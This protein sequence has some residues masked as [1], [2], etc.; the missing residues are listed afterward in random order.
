M[1]SYMQRSRASHGQNAANPAQESADPSEGEGKAQHGPALTPSK[2]SPAQENADLSDSQGKALH[3][4][5][6]AP[7]KT[8][9]DARVPIRVVAEAAVHP[10]LQ[11]AANRRQAAS[12]RLEKQVPVVDPGSVLHPTKDV[13]IHNDVIVAGVANDL[14]LFHW[15]SPLLKELKAIVKAQVIGTISVRAIE[16]HIDGIYIS[17]MRIRGTAK[18]KQMG[19]G[20]ALSMPHAQRQFI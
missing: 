13:Y 4:P 1:R 3:G 9:P 11:Q 10:A 6:L 19:I 18:I 5:A 2:K 8:S 15:L 17:D 20:H 12:A 7:S 14:W 16:L